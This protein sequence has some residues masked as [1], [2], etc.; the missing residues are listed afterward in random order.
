MP[1]IKNTFTSGK[2]NK[3]L[4]E[5]LVPKNE[6]RD[7][8]NIDIATTEGSD[9]G[10]A[11]NSYGN[12]KVSSLNITGGKCVGSLLNP[13]NQKI[14]WF[15]SGDSIDAIVEFDQVADS[16]EPIL[17][18]NHSGNVSFLS[19]RV[20]NGV[21]TTQDNLI[22]G[23]NVMEGLLFWTD[24]EN[25]PK[26][27]NIDRFKLG[28][29][30]SNIFSTTTKF[31]KV[32]GDGSHVIT[33]K[34]VAEE[35]ITVIKKYPLNAPFLK[36]DRDSSD[37]VDVAL[38]QL[39]HPQKTSRTSNGNPFSLGSTNSSAQYNT[40]TLRA[41]SAA[42]N[43]TTVSF[44]SGTLNQ[45]DW[46]DVS[47]GMTF[48]DNQGNTPS[49]HKASNGNIIG[50]A[51]VSSNNVTLT[52][53]PSTTIS[54]G[55]TV[56]FRRA[57][58]NHQTVGFWKY[59]DG[60]N[61]TRVKPP[62]TSSESNLLDSLEQ[63]VVDNNG[64]NIRIQKLVFTP[65]PNY[66]TGDIVVL[67]APNTNT[68]NDAED[69]VKIRLRLLQEDTN[70]LV[71][72]T[73]AVLAST[74]FRKVFDVVI[75]TIDPAIANMD[76][77]DLNSWSVK[78]ET[79][80]AIFSDNFVRFAYRWKYVDGEYSCISA[81]S[82]VAFL[83]TQE[84]YDLDSEVGF[85][86]N[87]VNTV[88][89][90]T[91]QDFDEQPD[92][93]HSLEI[94]SKFSNS[95]SIYK[96]QTIKS[97][98]LASFTS[99]VITS[100]QLNAMLPSNQ[101]LRAYDNVPVRAKAQEITANRLLYANY[102]QQ[103]DLLGEDPI[104]ELS[105]ESNITEEENS[106]AFKS[107]KSLRDYQLGVVLLDKYGRQ[108]PVFSP[109]STSPEKSKLSL[110]KDA[111][112]TAN[113]FFVKSD[114]MVPSWATHIKYYIKEPQGEYY[115]I[116]M[117]RIY[118]NINEEF[119]WVSFPSSD[120]NKVQEGDLIVLKKAHD[121]SG[122]IQTGVKPQYKV[123]AKQGVAPDAVKIKRKLLGRI[124]NAIFATSTSNTT[125]YPIEGGITVI[126]RGTENN[127]DA[128]KASSEVSSDNRY[129]RIGSYLKNTVSSYYQVESIVK[130]DGNQDGDFEDGEDYW[131]FTLV[132]P[133][134][135]D[136]NFIGVAPGSTGRAEYFELFED[137][138]NE[139][140]EEFQGKFFIKILKDDI[141][142][143]YV[144]SPN[145]SS[146]IVYG[147]KTTQHVYWI[148]NIYTGDDGNQETGLQG[149]DIDKNI[150]G[151]DDSTHL[152]LV[153]DGSFSGDE[154]IETDP[155]LW[156]KDGD[157]TRGTAYGIQYKDWTYKG[158]SDMRTIINSTSHGH[159]RY[160]IDQAWSW[161]QWSSRGSASGHQGDNHE[162][163]MGIGFR[164][165]SRNCNFRLFNIGPGFHRRDSPGGY[166]F[167]RPYGPRRSL[168]EKNYSLFKSLG[169]VGTKFRWTDDPTETI[170]TVEISELLD[171][172]NFTNNTNNLDYENRTNQGVRWRLKL[173][174]PI[175]WTPTHEYLSGTTTVN[176]GKIKP[177]D[178]T[179]KTDPTNWTG[180]VTGWTAD[181]LKPN[182]SE[183]QILVPVTDLD[184]FSSSSPAVFE[185]QP[186]DQADLNIF[187]E[188]PSTSL[189][190]KDNMFIETGVIKPDG[191][192]DADV[193]DANV[194]IETI[195]SSVF[196]TS[197]QIKDSTP[198]GKQNKHIVAGS[199]VTVFSKDAGGSALFKQK[200]ILTDDV[201]A[202]SVTRTTTIG[203]GPIGVTLPTFKY[204]T[205]L[206]FFNCYSYGNGVESNRV[207]DDFNAP[208]IDMGPRV[209]TTF[210]DVYKQET[211]GSGIIYSGVFNGKSGVN[212]LNQFIQAEKIT[213]DLNPSY[214][215]IQKLFTRNTNVVAFCEHKTLKILSN[216]DAM[217]NAD[218][219][220]QLL[221]TNN[222]L[223]QAV[224][225]AGEFGISK[226]PESFS[227][228][229]YR[230]YF[231]DKNRNAVLRLS[232]DGLTNIAAYGMST[233]FKENLSDSDSII[234]SYDEDKDT[235]NLTFNN[236]TISFSE[237]I[238]GWTSFK[239][240]LPENGFSVSGDY[241][242]V[243]GGDLYQHNSNTLRNNFYG[244]QYN[245]TLD[246]VFNDAP[247]TI[248]S[249]KGLNYEGTTS[250]IYQSENDDLSLTTNGWHATKIQTDKQNGK[251]PEFKEKEGKWF[252]FIQGTNNIIAN[253]DPQEFSVQGLGVC[254]A[255]AV[256]SGT[257]N[258]Q[259]V[260]N[261][262]IFSPLSSPTLALVGGI[263]GFSGGNFHSTNQAGN[264]A[265]IGQT[266]TN[267]G[268]TLNSS[269]KIT[270]TAVASLQYLKSIIDDLTPG[271]T[272]T[273]SATVTITANPD[274]KAMGFSQR[275]GVSANA[276][277]TT[278]GVISDTF[279]ATN[280]DIDLFKGSNVAGN[281]DNIAV[282]KTNPSEERYPKYIIN[283]HQSNATKTTKEIIVN[284]SSGTIASGGTENK[285][286]YVHPK[287]VNGQ[288]WSVLASNTTVTESS[289]PN[290]LIGTVVKTD[291]YIN[292]NTWTASNDHQGLHTNVVRLTVPVSGSMPAYD[293][294]SLLK[295][296]IVPNLTQNT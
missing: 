149:N 164:L 14:I 184:T 130:N 69:V 120:V 135:S 88:S 10:S 240:F 34:N 98:D 91:L 1:E 87:M 155:K 45:Q 56:G 271:E 65:R 9:I 173:D 136:I 230:V 264:P 12:L 251:I 276:R 254:S 124:E 241:Y 196:V 294:V 201:V 255:V 245:S 23:I 52:A 141:L 19:F 249:F 246:F 82:P 113:K 162:R 20:Q 105:M 188:T 4:D 53:A 21:R 257:H 258:T 146:G 289:D 86:K 281:M 208:T 55:T 243:F 119:A 280:S 159:Q 169:T 175:A 211:L 250:R 286:F 103:Y 186:N 17:I 166:E 50:V 284:R 137:R 190:I 24:G 68:S 213:K 46:N 44:A 177:Y 163:Q 158:H 125:G 127:N 290:T 268:F 181:E 214:G 256:A 233:F 157:A 263:Y 191:T 27:I 121:S 62:G 43:S 71:N 110:T 89:K 57:L 83:P 111:S 179:S 160:A 167:D 148:Q 172:N 182:T 174:K 291:G 22:T 77:A 216:K 222:V 134:E 58:S 138:E 80:T 252:N 187:H 218:G 81:F 260:Q 75:L 272:Y 234:G 104:F 90:I 84:G 70:F 235:Y 270:G 147:I 76:N 47:V 94:L 116:T 38:T 101:L 42:I 18:D 232:N 207:R 144:I 140:D 13:E 273:L 292:G 209:S 54:S 153:Y 275:S 26:K 171:V 112:Y 41:T 180:D 63:P 227:S 49:S 118:Q 7:A 200:L 108:T 78:K 154:S 221:S 37:S 126:I 123:L 152:S 131:E 236:K 226:N 92:D 217:F 73:H 185:V 72:S 29:A 229:G 107:I 170:Y 192:I 267:S 5:R 99:L 8:L 74:S 239:S 142:Q 168:I 244:V 156:A 262:R 6:Y 210:E 247:S 16:V 282:A 287:I 117:D 206:N 266:H 279:I 199:T 95:T 85:N 259:Y 32:Q 15:V 106:K 2:M 224:P 129:I 265:A 60:D 203:T 238:N 93:I 253:L 248:K 178:G 242:T 161:K 25:E 36:L 283:N 274:N 261:I 198:F 278:T 51:A 66:K 151:S 176:T 183:I 269:V 150:L 225:F 133:L 215:T 296:V 293:I 212:N 67:E 231:S 223:G 109:S 193:F 197:F 219:N 61:V 143:Q 3:D 48:T 39:T 288:K 35:H 165:G 40:T 114:F 139:F 33:S 11:Q 128:I 96:F 204:K 31:V 100:D 277:R 97:S 145:N 102:T 115:N 59:V 132:K 228:Y 285:Y 295:A 205:A 202:P 28:V 64:V 220:P 30:S 122:Q 189:I 237:S 195:T 79:D 194:Q